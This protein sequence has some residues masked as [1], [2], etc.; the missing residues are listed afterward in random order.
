MT[1]L[2]SLTNLLSRIYVP[3]LKMSINNLITIILK[4]ITKQ[5]YSITECLHLECLHLGCEDC[6]E[7]GLYYYVNG[8][9][10]HAMYFFKVMNKINNN[11]SS[12]FLDITNNLIIFKLIYESLDSDYRKNIMDRFFLDFFANPLIYK[13]NGYL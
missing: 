9:G 3:S 5:L 1:F 10:N 7:K 6:K 2:N 8:F 4:L 11:N 12:C 13:D